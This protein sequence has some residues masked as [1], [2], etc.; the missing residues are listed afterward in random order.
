MSLLLPYNYDICYICIM[1]KEFKIIQQ[2]ICLNSESMENHMIL[3]FMLSGKIVGISIIAY[4]SWFKFWDEQFDIT[5]FVIINTKGD[6]SYEKF[7]HD[8]NIHFCSK[9]EYFLVN[10]WYAMNLL[11]FKNRP[12]SLLF[13]INQNW[14]FYE[15]KV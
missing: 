8:R 4:P 14:I 10:G 5:N 12:V 7:V 6:E 15:C 3:L 11:Q 1:K 2:N 9:T 13:K